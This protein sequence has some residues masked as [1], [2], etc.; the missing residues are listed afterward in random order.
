[1]F[2]PAARGR[3]GE[4]RFEV[5]EVVDAPGG[6]EAGEQFVATAW[7]AIEGRRVA[8][9]LHENDRD[10]LAVGD[11]IEVRYVYRP[12]LNTI[13]IEKWTKVP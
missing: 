9:P 4:G 5:V 11:Q 7:V 1:M 3:T 10:A 8:I 2:F 12:N 13:S 6:I